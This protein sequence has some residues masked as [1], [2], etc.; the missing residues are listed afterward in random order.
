MYRIFVN[1]PI[2][3]DDDVAVVAVFTDAATAVGL[4]KN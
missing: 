4:F 2:I 1:A 3:A